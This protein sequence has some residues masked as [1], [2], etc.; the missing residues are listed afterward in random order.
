MKVNS[1]AKKTAIAAAIAF[2]SGSVFAGD[3]VVANPSVFANEI[4]GNLSENTTVRMPAVEFRAD[5]N[6]V[7]GVEGQ[8]AAANDTIKLTLEG[9]AVFGENYQDPNIWAQQ[10]ISVTIGSTALTAADILDVTG[11]TANDNQITITLADAV[12]TETL[13]TITLEG[14]KVKNLKETLERVGEGSTRNHK[15]T[16]EVRAVDAGLFENTP[17]V[18]A[19]YSINGVAVSSDSTG[20]TSIGGRAWLQ[21]SEDYKSFTAPAGGQAEKDDLSSRNLILDLGQYSFA[22]GELVLSG[23]AFAAGK[24]TGALFD[25]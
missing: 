7:N 17:A 3:L 16:V 19:F 8:E 15:V 18:P 24:E 12:G 11:G 4:F 22:R 23:T 21:A 25:F 13:D 1:L 6:V 20:Y 2:A 9:N 10:G 5:A 14:F